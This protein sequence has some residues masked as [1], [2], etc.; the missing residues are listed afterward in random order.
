MHWLQTHTTCI[1]ICM[2]V[3]IGEHLVQL[4][5]TFLNVDKILMALPAGTMPNSGG[6]EPI[7]RC[8]PGR[9]RVIFGLGESQGNFRGMGISILPWKKAMNCQLWSS[10]SEKPW[11][12]DPLQP[13]RWTGGRT[14]LGT[15]F[16][17]LGIEGL[18]KGSG[19]FHQVSLKK[20]IFQSP[21]NRDFAL[22]S[23]VP[24]KRCHSWG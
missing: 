22:N 9:I 21:G 10:C 18:E 8:M 3:S 14:L 13:P 16:W 4:S 6:A 24:W 11:K 15:R 17:S 19:A 7:R 1:C 2:Y 20:V 5:F 23:V 12:R